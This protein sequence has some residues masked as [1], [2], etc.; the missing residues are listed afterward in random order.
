MKI[1]YTECKLYGEIVTQQRRESRRWAM[2]L[3]HSD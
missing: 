2:V 1:G 3:P